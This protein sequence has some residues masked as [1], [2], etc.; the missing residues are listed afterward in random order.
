MKL[1][2]ADIIIECLKEQ[3]VDTIFGFP[4][5]AV[6][7]IYDALYRRG[8]GIRHILTSHEQGASHAADGYARASGKT[9]VCLATSGPG[10]TN[11]V[12][13]IA[14][15]YMDSVP[16]VAI[17]GQVPSALIGRDSFQ[18]VD[19]T[20]IT[21]PITK[22]NF[23]VKDVH[24]LAETMRKA[25]EIA[26]SGRPGPVLVD[27]C[28][29]A[30]AN[31]AEFI[32]YD[33]KKRLNLD[34]K[35]LF[36]E[37]D[38]ETA[39]QAIQSA[40]RPVIL[41]GGGTIIAG[42]TSLLLSLSGKLHIPVATTLMGTGAVPASYPL[43]TGLLGMHGTR[44]SNKVVSECDLLINIG[45]RFSDRVISD[46]KRFAPNA[47]IIHI[48]ADPAEINKNISVQFALT[49]KIDLILQGILDR[50][51]QVDETEW[52]KT[53]KNWKEEYRLQFPENGT[54][55]P[56]YII[57]KFNELTGSDAIITTEVGQNQIWAAQ[58]YDYIR[59][60]QYVSSGGLGTMGYGTGAAIGAQ[61]ANPDKK[62]INFAGD[63][64]FR[65]NCNELATAVHYKLPVIIA[66]L[67]NGTLGMV[68]Q[69]QTMFYD[70]RYSQTTLDRGPDFVK[71]ADAY[72]AVG[73]R[74]K[75]PQEVCPAIEKALA[76]KDV[77]VVMD[78]VI[79]IDERVLP[80]VPPGKGIDQLIYA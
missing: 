4:G 73:I 25:F 1:T 21:E 31:T 26:A 35:N 23:L 75:T 74:V 79:D 44:V 39:V 22:H 14:T 41:A 30:T 78:F 80:I 57:Q 59:P 69:W 38:L 67:N 76:C 77:P 40:S 52:A 15:A 72:G 46:M 19:I 63:G 66:V 7:N 62:V 65:M 16:L 68:R 8:A 58:Y 17:T 13:G 48:D 32:P 11:L 29:D 49:G 36:S 27:V 53:A 56:S 3:N 55:R 37:A 51:K 61:M 24:E 34:I 60:R 50:T 28:K 9:G 70:K 42:V 5:G 2:G 43:Y 10:A 33:G 20:G 54:L 64:S 6:L 71:L 47:R 12:T 18:E 45:A